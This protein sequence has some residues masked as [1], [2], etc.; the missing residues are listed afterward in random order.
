MQIPGIPLDICDLC[1]QDAAT[2]TSPGV[3][4]ICKDC[5]DHVVEAIRVLMKTKGIGYFPISDG[6]RN[7]THPARVYRCKEEHP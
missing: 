1:K 3:G 5:Q 6:T 2:I 7:N 4:Q